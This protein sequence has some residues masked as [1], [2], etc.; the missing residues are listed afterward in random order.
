MVQDK[1]IYN[2]RFIYSR[3]NTLWELTYYLALYPGAHNQQG[4]EIRDGYECM[5]GEILFDIYFFYY[6]YKISES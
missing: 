4:A 5:N 2:F 6:I 3:K 1:I